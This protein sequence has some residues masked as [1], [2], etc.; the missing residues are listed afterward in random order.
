[1]ESVIR[2]AV[3]LNRG[4]SVTEKGLEPVVRDELN[5]AQDGPDMGRSRSR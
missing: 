4:P 1:M 3:D 5:V 2:R